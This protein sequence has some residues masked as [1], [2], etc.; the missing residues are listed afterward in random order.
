MTIPYVFKPRATPV[1]DTPKSNL[2]V[3][4][5]FAENYFLSS[6]GWPRVQLG[7]RSRFRYWVPLYYNVPAGYE[8]TFRYPQPAASTIFS[9]TP[10][11]F[12]SR[13]ASA[14]VQQ[15]LNK[16]LYHRVLHR[17]TPLTW[18]KVSRRLIIKKR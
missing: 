18:V 12:R 14:F 17:K 4:N 13:F 8:K 7:Q 2:S 6:R 9:E 1:Q 15:N 11:A 3:Q 10:V 5:L 16:Q